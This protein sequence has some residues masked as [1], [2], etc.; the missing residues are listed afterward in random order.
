MNSLSVDSIFTSFVG[1]TDRDDTRSWALLL[2]G[3]SVLL[4]C[5]LTAFLI[6]EH[7]TAYNKPE[8]IITLK[9]ALAVKSSPHKLVNCAEY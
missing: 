3:G 6:G 2:A 5:C 4:A 9:T 8:V 7:L 1:D